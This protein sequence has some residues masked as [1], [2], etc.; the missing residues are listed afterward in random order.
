MS[1]NLSELIKQMPK[2]YY[3]CQKVLWAGDIRVEID[4]I[5]NDL[6]NPLDYEKAFR[7]MLK[8]LS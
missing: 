2:D 5:E 1:E 6:S 4:H 3:V 7:T 8:K